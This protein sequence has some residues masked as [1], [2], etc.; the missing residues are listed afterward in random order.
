MDIEGGSR[1]GLRWWICFLIFLPASTLG[2][3]LVFLLRGYGYEA[4]EEPAIAS[5]ALL[6]LFLLITLF[7]VGYS[8]LLGRSVEI[9]FS[10][11]LLWDL[12]SYFPFILL[13]LYFWPG[14]RTITNIGTMLFS[15]SLGLVLFLK[16]GTF[17]YH[18]GLA[19]QALVRPRLLLLA[20]VGLGA[21]F[22]M[23]LIAA[24][25]FCE[26]EALYGHWGLLI[27]SGRDIFLR[28]E[29]VDK[30]PFFIYA[31]A[32]SF[33]LFGWSEA[34]ARL[35]NIVASLMSVVLVYGLSRELYDEGVALLAAALLTFSPFHIQYAPTAFTDPFMVL[36]SLAAFY[37]VLRGYYLWGGLAVGLAVMSKPFGVLFL[38]LF[39]FLV[40]RS[41]WKR[42][43]RP[44]ITTLLKVGLRLGAGVLWAVIPVVIWDLLIRVEGI[45]W[46][47]AGLSRYGRV[48]LVSWDA[49]LPRFE[50]WLGYLGYIT[51]SR[52]LNIFILVGVP[53]LLLW[54]LW[55]RRDGWGADFG[56]AIFIVGYM[57]FYTLLS[58]NIWDRYLLGMAPLVAILLAR[59]LLLPIDLFLKG[60]RRQLETVYPFLLG[61][62]LLAALLRP[63]GLALRYRFPIGGDHGAYEGIDM[64]ANY[65][66]GEVP[67]KSILYH[68]WLG[69]HFSFYMFDL[70]LEFYYYPSWEFI[71][72]TAEAFPEVKKYIVFPSWVGSQEEGLRG[73]LRGRGWELEEVYR[74]YRRDGT[75]SFTAYEVKRG[76]P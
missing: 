30:P 36:F 22:S 4:L 37:L 38:P 18:A 43:L 70:P 8:Y 60:S 61:F 59:A 73:L 33:K 12:F 9:D 51:G 16:V 1:S 14:I 69:W 7:W 21:L 47:S 48:T 76:L 42:E 2:L 31:L 20:L 45:D 72:E 26:D 68:K 40:V 13:L 67:P 46:F 23:S 63:T 3:F 34:A 32:L 55:R 52:A 27:A 6:T 24:N 19:W 15:L 41:L 5:V 39:L 75:V 62:L 66:R 11:A 35:P 65:F 28:G 25:R 49:I 56:F 64:L 10:R 58:F 71:M 54:G 57:A 17:L 50:E 74:T 29:V 44:D 53:L